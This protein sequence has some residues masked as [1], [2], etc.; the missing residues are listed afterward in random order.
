VR[1]K[2]RKAGD[3]DGPANWAF[4]TY[5]EPAGAAAALGAQ[6]LVCR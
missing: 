4:V 6:L 1:R 3:A 2:E 5:S